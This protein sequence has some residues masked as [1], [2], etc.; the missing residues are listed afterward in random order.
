MK[1]VTLTI[2][3]SENVIQISPPKK[4]DKSTSSLSHR[5][6]L[7]SVSNLLIDELA[8]QKAYVA[9]RPDVNEDTTAEDA[10]ATFRQVNGNAAK[11]ASPNLRYQIVK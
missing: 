7:I 8:W 5:R 6:S 9:V 3:R 2:P 10:V 4:K 11:K 1:I